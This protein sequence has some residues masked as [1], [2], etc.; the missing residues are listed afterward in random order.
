MSAISAIA[1]SL[2]SPAAHAVC[3][4][5]EPPAFE[6]VAPA[7]GDD[8][9]ADAL[10]WLFPAFGFSVTIDGEE[11]ERLEGLPAFVAEVEPGQHTLEVFETDDLATPLLTSTFTTLDAFAAPAAT[12]EGD[13][14]IE[15]ELTADFDAACRDVFPS[16]C[17]DTIENP[18][19]Y[20]AQMQTEAFVW[21]VTDAD[22][23]R[24]LQSGRCPP[25]LKRAPAVDEEVCLSV[26]A[27][28]QAGD[29]S[30]A[31]EICQTFG[32][33]PTERGCSAMTTSATAPPRFSLLVLGLLG[34]G[35][36]R[37]RRRVSR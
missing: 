13:G 7:E 3:P 26:V 20:I 17:T 37:S 32:E 15:R 30:G 27:I 23:S 25:L 2:L 28:N 12:P 8:A 4:E 1:L 33:L 22:G 9:P 6:F 19:Y 36:F 34:V 21:E 35:C 16:I 10:I 31:T 24:R 18:L 14:L 11:Q 29:R 5:S